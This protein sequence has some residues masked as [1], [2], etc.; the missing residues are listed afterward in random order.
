MAWGRTGVG[1]GR[2]GKHHL[3][4]AVH[5]LSEGESNVMGKFGLHTLQGS[6]KCLLQAVIGGMNL[7]S[8]LGEIMLLLG[9]LLLDMLKTL[10]LRSKSSTSLF[11][12]MVELLALSLKFNQSSFEFLEPSLSL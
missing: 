5:L 12:P 11:E 8:G 2:L 1:P 6:L 9:H 4:E 7:R 3:L 10:V